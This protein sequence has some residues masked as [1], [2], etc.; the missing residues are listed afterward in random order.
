MLPDSSIHGL[1]IKSA[2]LYFVRAF[3]LLERL[4]LHPGQLPLLVALYREDGL[5]QKELVKRLSVKPSTVAVMIKRMER[6]GLLQRRPDD[7][8]QRVTRICLTEEG[9]QIREQVT[10]VMQQ[11]DREMFEGISSEERLLLRRLF[12]QI[13]QNLEAAEEP[14][15]Q[16]GKRG[17]P[18]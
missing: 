6:N 16:P 11:L 3:H 15:S 5:S 14:T 8:D 10:H 7:K 2:R 9:R 4:G 12:L 17:M 1:M 13:M 18:C